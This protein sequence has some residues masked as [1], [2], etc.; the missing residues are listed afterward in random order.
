MQRILLHSASWRLGTHTSFVQVAPWVTGRKYI[1]RAN[2]VLRSS[3]WMWIGR[4]S[5]NLC[6]WQW[7]RVFHSLSLLCLVVDR[8]IFAKFSQMI[9]NKSIPL[10]WSVMFGCGW[11]GFANLLPGK[12]DHNWAYSTHLVCYVWMWMGRFSNPFAM[13]KQMIMNE[14]IPLTW[15]VMF[16]CGWAGFPNQ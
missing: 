10:T 11:A 13:E 3:N 9:M 2:H 12:H 5:Q 4:F 8:Q 15:S 6:K 16:G 1:K 14:H 7:T